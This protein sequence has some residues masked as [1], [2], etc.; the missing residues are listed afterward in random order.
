MH[1]VD[2]A[3]AAARERNGAPRA[4]AVGE[5]LG[6]DACEVGRAA[7]VGVRGAQDLVRVGAPR[8]AVPHH[9]VAGAAVRRHAREQH[10]GVGARHGRH[11]HV[12]AGFRHDR[13]P[14]QVHGRAERRRVA[15]RARPVRH[16]PVVG[17]VVERAHEQHVTAELLE[18]AR[19]GRPWRVVAHGGQALGARQRVEHRGRRDGAVGGDAEHA[20]A[21]LSRLVERAAH[22]HGHDAQLVTAR[23]CAGVH[24]E[25]GFGLQHMR[26]DRVVPR[27]AS[28]GEL[29][30]VQ[31]GADHAVGRADVAVREQQHA[32]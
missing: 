10:R 11:A 28:V 16:R 30:R 5:V 19:G 8:V 32:R 27:E 21:H 14:R 15:P 9:C 24:V 4:E 7:R 3:A 18:H 6:A 1:D 25:R 20:R 29:A 12:L 31:R 22:R 26:G 23:R 17:A 13:G 2:G